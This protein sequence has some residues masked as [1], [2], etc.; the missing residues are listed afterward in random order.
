M[1]MAVKRSFKKNH[2]KVIERKRK[3]CSCWEI[4]GGWSLEGYLFN[5]F[6]TEETGTCL[7]DDGKDRHHKGPTSKPM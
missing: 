3:G 2:C 4:L 7:N 1:E 5:W 6:K